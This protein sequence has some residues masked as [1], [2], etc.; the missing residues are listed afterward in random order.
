MLIKPCLL[1][2]NQGLR[3]FGSSL[4][5]VV[6]SHCGRLAWCQGSQEEWK[7]IGDLWDWD[8]PEEIFSRRGKWQLW[9]WGSRG[10]WEKIKA[11]Y[12]LFSGEWSRT[13]HLEVAD[14]QEAGWC[15]EGEN[16]LETNESNENHFLYQKCRH[17]L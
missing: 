5:M 2:N 1:E 4:E 15:R 11:K 17:F 16:E 6:E 12:K 8:G 10:V 9:S 7:W 13:V 3:I 14:R